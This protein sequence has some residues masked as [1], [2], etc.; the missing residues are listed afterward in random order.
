M[1]KL[2]HPHFAPG[3]VPVETMDAIVQFAVEMRK[4][5]ID[6]M[7]VMKP[8]EFKDASFECAAKPN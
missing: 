2:F 8:A 3:E 1:L 7:A 5:V 6:Q 4:R